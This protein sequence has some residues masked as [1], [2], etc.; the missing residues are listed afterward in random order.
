MSS[1]AAVLQQELPWLCTDSVLLNKATF[2]PSLYFFAVIVVKD[3]PTLAVPPV[4]P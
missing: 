4:I 2:K 3:A 1:T